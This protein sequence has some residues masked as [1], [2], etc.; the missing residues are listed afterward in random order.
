MPDRTTRIAANG[1][2]DAIKVMLASY[3]D[4]YPAMGQNGYL[5]IAGDDRVIPFRRVN[6]YNY[7]GKQGEGWAPESLYAAEQLL[8]NPLSTVGA[9]LFANQTLQR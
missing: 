2:S 5:V 6:I 1:V 7:L 4:D 8:G 9:A 3:L